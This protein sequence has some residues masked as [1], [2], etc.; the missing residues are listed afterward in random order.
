MSLKKTYDNS[1]YNDFPSRKLISSKGR[2][3]QLNTVFLA[4]ILLLELVILFYAKN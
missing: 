3:I 4:V 1:A 2:G